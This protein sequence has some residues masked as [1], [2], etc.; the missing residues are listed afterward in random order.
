MKKLLFL[1][2]V[3]AV[4]GGIWLYQNQPGLLPPEVR[5]VMDQ[6]KQIVDNLG[7]TV[8]TTVN[9]VVGKSP[10][11]L[12]VNAA[13]PLPSD[14]APELVNCYTQK[15]RRFLVSASTI[16]LE[17][18]AYEA[19]NSMFQAA[20]GQGVSGFVVV[21]GFSDET[22][23]EHRTGLAMDVTAQDGNFVSGPQYAWL[24]VHCWDYGFVPRFPAGKETVTGVP[25]D[26]SHFRY[27]GREAARIMKENSWTL[28]EYTA[29]RT[30]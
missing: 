11:V 12:L 10:E 26:P 21:R 16:Q 29:S 5:Q 24:L 13:H 6:G 25:A 3:I 4:V 15:D 28:E 22:E 30:K 23:P 19:A 27:V 14:Y 2:L 17:K 8:T 9:T 7:G 18:T 20:E 1:I